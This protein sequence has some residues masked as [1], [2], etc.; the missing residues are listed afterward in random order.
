M[1][2]RD[3]ARAALDAAAALRQQGDFGGARAELS[4]LSRHPDAQA[5]GEPTALGLPRRLH[6]AFLRLAKAEGDALARIGYQFHLVPPPGRFAR[7]TAVTPDDRRAIAAANR[8]PV[9]HSLHQIWIGTLPVPPSAAAWAAHAARHGY[10]YRLWRE[11]DLAGLGLGEAPAYREMLARGD[12]PGAVDAARYA[13]LAAEGGIYLDC[14]WYPA[15]DDLAFHDLLPLI[16]LTALAEEIP[17]L[18]G[19]GALLLA[20]SF[21]A[22]PPAHPVFIRLAEVLP[23]I[24]A[25]M[26]KAPAW[27]STGPLIFTLLARNGAV[28]L[29]D[30]HFVAAH[31]PRG[32]PLAEVE[33]IRARAG[34]E[35]LGPLIAWKSW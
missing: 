18:T 15:R 32:A 30:A 9:P 7:W 10:A 2:D 1:T 26:P 16:G 4:A 6:A 22:A 3:R 25:D 17:R 14:D 5:L 28:A 23:E 33:T 27:W 8:R 35:D 24:V 13:I 34:A 31:L 12:Y 29:A 20:N 19:A 21:L 11:D